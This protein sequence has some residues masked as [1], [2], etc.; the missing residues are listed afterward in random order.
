MSN[1]AAIFQ[2]EL[3]LFRARL[4]DG[5]REGSQVAVPSPWPTLRLPGS[6]GPGFGRDGGMKY[7]LFVSFSEPAEEILPRLPA[8]LHEHQARMRCS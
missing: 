7:V 8:E 3:A 4:G 1:E 6:D 2:P 5:P